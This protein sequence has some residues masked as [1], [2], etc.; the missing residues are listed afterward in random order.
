MLTQG[1]S[2]AALEETKAALESA[3]RER[4]E[5]QASLEE[6]RTTLEQTQEK[7]SELEAK[8]ESDDSEQTIERLQQVG[9]RGVHVCMC[10]EMCVHLWQCRSLS[11]FF[12]ALLALLSCYISRTWAGRVKVEGASGYIQQEASRA[13]ITVRASLCLF[14]VCFVCVCVCLEGNHF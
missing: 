14:C 9:A 7:L 5:A 10:A 3:E 13:S 2:T 8:A 11:L 4:D 6:T 12:T 1:S